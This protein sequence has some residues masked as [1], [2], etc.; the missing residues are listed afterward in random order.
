MTTDAAGRIW[1]AHWGG[2]CVSCHDPLTAHELCRV[3]LP[4]AT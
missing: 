2:A 3:A 1:I 4:T